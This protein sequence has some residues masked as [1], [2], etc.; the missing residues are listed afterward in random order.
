M[1]FRTSHPSIF[2]P[3]DPCPRPLYVGQIEC[4]SIRQEN[5]DIPARAST[6]ESRI[7]PWK[8]AQAGCPNR[9]VSCLRQPQ[10]MLVAI[11]QTVRTSSTTLRRRLRPPKLVDPYTLP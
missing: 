4:F 9:P 2:H 1:V 11:R 6:A 5:V 8:A 10:K 3:V 7:D